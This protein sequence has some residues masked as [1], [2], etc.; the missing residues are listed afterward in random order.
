MAAEQNSK[1]V[2]VYT[3]PTTE[4]IPQEKAD[5]EKFWHIDKEML[6]FKAHY[7]LFAG[8]F[9]ACL[10]YLTIFA[11][12]RVGISAS[13]L[14]AILTTQR[15]V[16]IFTKPSIGYVSDY[17]NKLKVIICTL[18]VVSTIFLLLLLVVPKI[19]KGKE[20]TTIH[21]AVDNSTCYELSDNSEAYIKCE[22]YH[23]DSSEFTEIQYF[24]KSK[25]DCLRFQSLQ[26]MSDFL[27]HCSGNKKNHENESNKSEDIKVLIDKLNTISPRTNSFLCQVCNLAEKS[28]S[29]N[30]EYLKSSTNRIS[31]KET[32]LS[33]FQRY[34]FWLYA[35]ISTITT[36]FGNSLFTLTD[37]ACCESVQKRGAQFGRQNL[38]GSIGWGLMSPISGLLND[39]TGDF[40]ASWLLMAAM[41]FVSLLNM[42]K[43]EIIKPNFSKNLMKD[44]GTVLSSKEFLAF[45]LCV[46]M[47]GVGTGIMW[48]YFILFLTDMGGSRFLCGM[49]S[50]VQCFF[51][52]IPLLFFSGWIIKKI[53][54]FNVL[55]LALTAYTIRFFWY[56]QLQNPWLA[57]PVEVLQGCTEGLFYSNM[58]SFAKLS[59]KPGTEA[60]TQAV[61]VTAHEG[62]G[63][64]IG[65]VIAGLGFDSIGGHRTFLELLEFS[66]R[67]RV[68][69]LQKMASEKNGKNVEIYTVSTSESVQEKKIDNRKKFWHIDQEMLPFKVH[70]FLFV[71][72]FGACL[73]YI[74]I[75]A[76]KR[77][78]ISAS[79]LSAILTT[80]RCIFIFTKPSIGYVSDY[81][82]KLKAIIF[83][84]SVVTSVFFFLL[85]VVPKIEN[86]ATSANLD[87]AVNNNT[88]YEFLSISDAYI[89]CQ[90]QQNNSFVSIYFNKSKYE[91]MCTQSLQYL[92]GFLYEC[93]ENKTNG[94]EI[95]DNNA[96]H[97]IILDKGLKT[98]TPLPNSLSCKICCRLNDKC[99]SISCEVSTTEIPIETKPVSDFQKYQFWCFALLTTIS[100]ACANSLFTLTDTACC[101]SVQKTGGEFGRQRL[102]GAIGWGLLSPVGGLLNDYTGDFL[103]SWILMA[104]MSFLS[105][106]N[107]TKLEMAKPKF[108]KNLMKDVGTVLSSKEFLAF[109]FCV[110]MNGVG[111]GIMWFYLVLFLTDIGGSR[112]LCGMVMFV[113]CF[114]GEIPFMFYSAW[115][116]KKIGHFNV[117][118]LAL[119]AYS[120]RF[121][122]YSQLQNPWFVLPAEVLHGFTY[123][124]FYT[125]VASFAKLSAKPGTEA[126]TQAVLFTAH[127]GLG[128]GIGCIIAGLGFDSIGGHRTF[129]YTSIYAGCATILSVILH[130]LIRKQKR[131][132][133]LTQQ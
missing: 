16:C 7:F 2:D 46:L 117:L 96:E 100:M 8:A 105:L 77:V 86:G 59:A 76:Q 72:A 87:H 94:T 20:N 118:T 4:S 83:T 45:K 64:G 75:F 122:W 124:L 60:T 70:Y 57:L 41:S 25:D 131:S 40:L 27:N 47:N 93:S 5:K 12:K 18:S 81:F 97:S 36:V 29:M 106:L 58:A 24:N 39:Y 48:F 113:Q 80:Q 33:D 79:A 23:N 61:L 91:D 66:I 114:F 51:G 130:L 9:G 50:F 63:I 98:I 85:L 112:F 120:V 14:A 109:K 102:W 34:Q 126:T 78:G 44:V 54:H 116:I 127:E 90:Y 133:I 30:C 6:R 121:L 74:T 52:E 42:T 65:C 89:V 73:P 37:T 108:S 132:F 26:N 31:I 125:N 10:P 11:Q 53:G 82:N 71:G 104:I 101:E 38:W 68:S 35:F 103:A 99:Q 15:C 49:V 1:N 19:E 67:L 3:V 111:T 115:F 22:F 13:A 95:V 17:F 119:T 88:R 56:S 84:L 21:H 69:T 128:V 92:S 55:T 43:L 28:Q 129:L 110:L 32:R 123:G 62:L 107:M